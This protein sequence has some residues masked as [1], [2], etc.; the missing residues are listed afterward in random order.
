[1]KKQSY[2][3][4]IIFSTIFLGFGTTLTLFYIMI[5][6]I[7]LGNGNGI[8]ILYLNQYGEMIPE[9]ILL[10][11]FIVLMLFGLKYSYKEWSV[12]RLNEVRVE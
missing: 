5:Q 10:S 2:K 11:S 7:F 3:K 4:F 9:F 1:M 12:T 8:H 6:E